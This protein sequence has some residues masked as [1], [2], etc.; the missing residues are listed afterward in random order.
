[1]GKDRWGPWPVS[2]ASP[3]RPRLPGAALASTAPPVAPV[4]DPSGFPHITS[5]RPSPVLLSAVPLL[6]VGG[7]TVC[8]CVCR[9][10][11]ELPPLGPFTRVCRPALGWAGGGGGVL[12]SLPGTWL[13]S[14][15]EAAQSMSMSASRALHVL[16]LP[17]RRSVPLKCSLHSQ[18]A[19]FEEPQRSPSVLKSLRCLVDS[20]PGDRRPEASRL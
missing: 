13:S 1:M 10:T 7:A 19:S 9:D 12:S 6:R 14:G 5:P 4:Q 17:V 11:S 2:T 18:V 3:S 16:L 20:F 8:P 15:E